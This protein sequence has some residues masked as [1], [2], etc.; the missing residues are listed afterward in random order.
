MASAGGK[1][2]MGIGGPRYGIKPKV[3]PTKVL[4]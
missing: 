3:M 1:A 4:V 2:G